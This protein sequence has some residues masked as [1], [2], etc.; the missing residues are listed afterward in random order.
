MLFYTHLL[1]LLQP[2]VQ[3]FYIVTF[4]NDAKLL[5]KLIL[6]EF[7][8]ANPTSV[9]WV[10]PPWNVY[11]AKF[12]PGWEGHPVRQTKLPALADHPTYHVNVN[13]RLYGQEGYPT[14]ASYLN[15]LSPTSM[16]TGR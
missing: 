9:R 14:L 12:D 3:W 6:R 4:N 15:Y 7:S 13:E 1:L 5:P 16:Y 11:M 2:L 10:T 8:I